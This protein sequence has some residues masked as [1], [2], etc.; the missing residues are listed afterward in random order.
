MQDEA[1]RRPAI[2]T[3]WWYETDWL[4][5]LARWALVTALAVVGL[6][7]AFG[8]L[9]AAAGPVAEEA[10]FALVELV[11]ASR[12]PAAHRLLAALDVLVWLGLG[13]TLLGFASLF[14]RWA[15]R[16]AAVLAACGVGQLI[17]ALGGYMRLGA[18][19]E[20]AA[21]HAA[22]APDQQATLVQVYLTVAEIISAHFDIGQLL[23]GVGFLLLGSVGLSLAGFPRWLAVWLG[24]SGLWA[25]TA[26]VAAAAGSTLFE[27][28][29]LVYAILGLL[30]PLL[31]I[32]LAF[33]RSPALAPRTVAS[34]AS[35]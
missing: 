34:M 25:I 27:S 26:Q 7:G 12:S 16:R 19:N 15:P 3:M 35:S 9:M 18:V 17:G 8:M 11:G 23:Y 20:L 6:F 29:F 30:A 21:R 22:A 28:A 14:A 4:K 33:W 2:T 32:A 10:D 13:G 1:N 5:F 31:A 24:L